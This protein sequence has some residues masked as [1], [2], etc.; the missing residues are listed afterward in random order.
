LPG[1]LIPFAISPTRLV[2]P[3][4]PF[5]PMI[6]LPSHSIT[7]N[8]SP[9]RRLPVGLKRSRSRSITC[10]DARASRSRRRPTRSDCEAGYDRD[11]LSRV[12]LGTC[13]A[14]HGG[15]AKGARRLRRITAR[16]FE[17]LGCRG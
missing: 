14:P 10:T 8:Q 13:L 2:S 9:E 7:S 15:L 16:S 5:A 4:S 17:A 11:A 6:G 3:A 1:T 12:H